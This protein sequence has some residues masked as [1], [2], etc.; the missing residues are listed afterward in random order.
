MKL[1][2]LSH[3]GKYEGG[4]QK[5]LVDLIKGVKSKY[6]NVEIYIIFPD[7]GDMVE[8]CRPYIDG[9]RII[10]MTWWLKKKR[11]SFVKKASLWIKILYKKS[12]IS[13]YIKIIEPNY[14]I[15]NTITIPFLAFAS[16]SHNIKHI[17]FIHEMPQTWENYHFIWN[18]DLIY[19][20]VNRLSYKVLVPSKYAKK[21]YDNLISA[22]KVKVITQAVEVNKIADNI[23]KSKNS[24]YSVLLIGSF[25]SNKGQMQLLNAVKNIVDSGKDILCYL[26]GDD[27]GNKAI[28]QQYINDNHLN[29]NVVIAPFS[30]QI[31]QFYQ[32]TDVLIVCS[33]F[34]TFGRVAVEAQMFRV[35]VIASDTGVHSETVKDG[36]NGF[37]HKKGDVNDLTFKIEKLRDEKVREQFCQQ[38][39]KSDLEKYTP[40]NFATEF[41]SFLNS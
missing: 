28:C 30:P 14:T 13:K 5:C 37:I 12:Q 32:L 11:P 19:K 1:L 8:V 41:Y 9:Y 35:P 29:E 18:S 20:I 17:W 15:T 16:R 23:V 39:K 34:E 40:I 21:H 31:E 7:N 26:V 22:D 6:Q 24:R 4:A 10:P 3:S 2:F 36:I 25:D 38:I 33:S 27:G